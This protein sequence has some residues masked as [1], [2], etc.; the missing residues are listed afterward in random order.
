MPGFTLLRRTATTMC[1]VL[2]AAGLSACS[3]S[4]SAGSPSGPAAG[5]IVLGALGPYSGAFSSTYGA[6]PKVLSAWEQTVNAAG[7]IG[8]KKVSIII[9]DTGG[10]SADAGVAAVHELIGQDHVKAIV[11]NQDANDLA[12]APYAASQGVPVISATTETDSYVDPNNF[13]AQGSAFAVVYGLGQQ[14]KTLGGSLGIAY[15]AED[16]TCAQQAQLLQLFV[17]AQ[18]VTVPVAVKVPASTADFTAYCQ[19]LKGAHVDTF[20]NS[21]SDELAQRMND[22]CFQQGLS[23]TQVISGALTNLSWKTDPVYRGSVVLDPV[24]PFFDTAVPGVKQYRAALTK[25]AAS[26][27]GTPGDNSEALR[28]WASVQLFAA[29]A[30]KAGGDITSAAIKS[31]LPKLN[32]DTLDGIVPP[33]AFTAGKAAFAECYFRWAPYGQFRALDGAKPTCIPAATIGP[34]VAAVLKSLHS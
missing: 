7:G 29:A 33:I 34:L 21:L 25:Y 15:C 4:G 1:V 2:T 14:A 26:V 6:V 28:A 9:K 18:Q 17:K 8:G 13:N 19:E 20:F 16:P 32:G 11:A 27:I 24:A 22:S 12:W 10:G 31:A 30:G 3:S 5:E 23:A